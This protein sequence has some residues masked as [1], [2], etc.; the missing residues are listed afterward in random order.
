MRSEKTM[1]TGI[2]GYHTYGLSLYP[3]AVAAWEANLNENCMSRMA[4]TKFPASILW[5][6]RDKADRWTIEEK[7]ILIPKFLLGKTFDKA[8]QP[9]QDFSLLIGIRNHIVHFRPEIVP[10]KGL[11]ELSQR[12]IT[13]GQPLSHLWHLELES[14]ECVRWGINVISDMIHH[15]ASLLYPNSPFSKTDSDLFKRISED[16]ARATFLKYQAP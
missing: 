9:Y 15:L 13:L 3:L 12:H 16:E 4:E 8:V 5:D 7:T 1:P 14:T 6:I 2:N 11:K 10:K